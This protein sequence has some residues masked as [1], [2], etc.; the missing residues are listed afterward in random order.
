MRISPTISTL[1]LRKFFFVALDTDTKKVNPPSIILGEGVHGKA[2]WLIA[3]NN[4]CGVDDLA[5][6]HFIYSD[7]RIHIILSMLFIFFHMDIFRY[8]S[9]Y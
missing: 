4:A 2:C 5:A 8:C 1:F 7:K 9:D 6:E 3:Y